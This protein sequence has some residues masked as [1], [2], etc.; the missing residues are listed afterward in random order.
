MDTDI[1]LHAQRTSELVNEK[2]NFKWLVSGAALALAVLIGGGIWKRYSMNRKERELQKVYFSVISKEED[3][4]IQ[5]IIKN[6]PLLRSFFNGEPVDKNE[7]C[8]RFEEIFP[9]HILEKFIQLGNIA[10]EKGLI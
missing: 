6:D 5:R 9:E 10:G 7:V 1:Y 8:K 2:F 4:E 3:E